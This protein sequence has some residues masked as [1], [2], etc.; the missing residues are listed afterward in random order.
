MAL[1]N[2]VYAGRLNTAVLVL[3]SICSEWLAFLQGSRESLQVILPDQWFAPWHMADQD[4]LK[5]L[6][7][8]SILHVKHTEDETNRS[9]LG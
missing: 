1:T 7:V 6:K 8:A 3:L 5:S 9:E 4:A 2:G